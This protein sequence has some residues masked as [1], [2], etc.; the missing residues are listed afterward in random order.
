MININDKNYC[1]KSKRVLNKPTF[2]Q[3]LKVS[4]KAKDIEKL[5]EEIDK[6]EPCSLAYIKQMIIIAQK[7]CKSN[8]K[9]FLKIINYLRRLD[10]RGLQLPL[11]KLCKLYNY[12][13]KL[14][15]NRLTVRDLLTLIKGFSSLTKPMQ[16]SFKRIAFSK[17]QAKTTHQLQRFGVVIKIPDQTG[18]ILSTLKKGRNIPET[19]IIPQGFRLG[20]FYKLAATALKDKL[21]GESSPLKKEWEKIAGEDDLVESFIKLKQKL[22]YQGCAPTTCSSKQLAV[23]RKFGFLPK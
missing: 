23:L 11:N 13:P 10:K 4:K 1:I 12:P 5:L 17:P 2:I 14:P 20:T 8:P 16:G 3:K 15:D 7:H 19:I 6:K 9:L 18:K 21:D 22:A